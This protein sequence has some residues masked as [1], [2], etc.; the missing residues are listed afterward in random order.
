MNVNLNAILKYV[1]ITNMRVQQKR[2]GNENAKNR[3]I[4]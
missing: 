1:E 4:G 2:R 3:D